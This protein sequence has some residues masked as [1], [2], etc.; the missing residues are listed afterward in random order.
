[1]SRRLS[2][3]EGTIDEAVGRSRTAGL[4]WAALS[5]TDRADAIENSAR[6]LDA[7]ADELT[8]IAERETHLDPERLGGELRRT[9]DQLRSFAAYIRTGRH[10]DIV[11]DAPADGSL[12]LRRMKVPLGPVAV[13]AASNFPFAFS[14][15]GGDTASA[16]AAGCSVVIKSHPGHP[17][18]SRAVFGILNRAL[19]DSGALPGTIA[20]VEGF[21]AGIELVS[22]PGIV[23]CAFTGSNA[24]GRSLFDLAQ[25][26][27]VPIPFYG[28]L[29]SINPTFVSQLAVTRRGAE[30]AAG[31]VDSFTRGAGQFCTKPGVIALPVGHGLEQVLLHAISAV[32]GRRLLTESIADRFDRSER[33]IASAPGVRALLASRTITG[34]TTPGLYVTGIADA[35][36]HAHLVLEERFGPTAV[37]VEY[38][39]G[40]DLLEL[41]RLFDGTLTATVHAEPEDDVSSLLDLL[42]SRA[43]RIIWN[44]WPTGVAVSAAM[45]HGGPYPSSTSP[46]FT[47]VGT[48]AIERF[49]RPIAFQSAPDHVLPIPLRDANSWGVERRVNG[50]GFPSE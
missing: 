35:R 45:Q 1:M 38:G 20:L 49:L 50:V 43:G 25:R 4:F 8:A 41:A 36:E 33:D 46:L 10:L 39:T 5:L 28:E 12:D 44:G 31:F 22:H 9:T 14:V 26:R 24:A 3:G 2:A 32:Q 7:H 23:A 29:G 11:I 21:E 30:I 47:S 17:E 13:F 6:E 15:A 16:L 48:S 40:D 27:D 34:Q 42:A 37:I 19:S 18:L